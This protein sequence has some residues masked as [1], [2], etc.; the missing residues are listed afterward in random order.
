M[1]THFQIIEKTEDFNG[2]NV[3]TIIWST[4]VKGDKLSFTDSL[5]FDIFKR[6]GRVVM[7]TKW[8]QG[9]ADVTIL[10]RSWVN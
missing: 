8:T 10:K 5:M 4:V 6:K 9:E 3:E 7:L 2:S 1:A